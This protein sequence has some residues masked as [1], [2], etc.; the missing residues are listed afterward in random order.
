MKIVRED[1]LIRT[2]EFLMTRE[3]ELI[4]DEVRQAI[5]SVNYFS[6]NKFIINP[7][8]KGNG[9]KPIKKSFVETL[10]SFGWKGEER[11]TI[12][13]GVNPGPIDAVKEF[14]DDLFA[15]E[16]ETGNISSSHRALNKIATGIIQHNLI[17]GILVL[18]TKELAQYL[19]DR[20]GNF[21][22]LQPY[23][24]LYSNLIVSEGIICVIS[25]TYDDTSDDAPLIPKGK[26]GNNKSL[27]DI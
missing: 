25:V 5:K 19:T 12:V 6:D 9:V 20:I 10:S 13:D 21:E 18:P 26:D 27:E 15:V 11:M 17:G 4:L 16:W 23:F 2:G 1:F 24:A 14:G 7:V 22:E 8:K 3:F